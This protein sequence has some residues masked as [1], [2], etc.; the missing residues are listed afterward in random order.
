ME[1][2]LQSFADNDAWFLIDSPKDGVIV[3][4]KSVFE[5]KVNSHGEE[6]KDFCLTFCKEDKEGYVDAVWEENK[7]RESY[8]GFIFMH[9]CAGV[10]WESRKQKSVSIPSTVAACVALLEPE[11]YENEIFVYLLNCSITELLEGVKSKGE[12]H[13]CQKKGRLIKTAPHNLTWKC[14]KL[15]DTV[16]VAFYSLKVRYHIPQPMHRFNYQ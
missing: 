15:P 14:P 9:S 8:T 5:A 13:T 4:N 3:D 7:D 10:F 1:N 2:E 6:T 16:E 12:T 11:K